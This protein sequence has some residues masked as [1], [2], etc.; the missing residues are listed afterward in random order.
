ME[1]A[2]YKETI[3]YRQSKCVQD[4][5]SSFPVIHKVGNVGIFCMACNENKK[6][7]YNS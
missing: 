6:E 3:Y 2:K 5:Q 7:I 4:V 1:K